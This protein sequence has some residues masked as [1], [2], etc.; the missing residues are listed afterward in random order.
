VGHFEVYGSLGGSVVNERLGADVA[1]G[2]GTT[3]FRPAIRLGVGAR[4]FSS[5]TVSWRIDFS[6][7][8]VLYQ[9]LEQNILLIQFALALN[10][11]GTE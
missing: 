2:T 5:K 6:N 9:G 3:V 11:G 1:S 4:I 10:F 8:F 7:D